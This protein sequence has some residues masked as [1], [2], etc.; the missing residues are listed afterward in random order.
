MYLNFILKFFDTLRHLVPRDIKFYT[1]KYVTSS[2]LKD[3]DE[4]YYG[5]NTLSPP[6][7]FENR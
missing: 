5:G 4:I 3:D 2:Y 6:L 1:I 7:T